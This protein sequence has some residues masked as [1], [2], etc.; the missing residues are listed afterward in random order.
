M[1]GSDG[2]LI[3]DSDS[4]MTWPGADISGFTYFSACTLN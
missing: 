1:Q 2:L 4:K 3:N